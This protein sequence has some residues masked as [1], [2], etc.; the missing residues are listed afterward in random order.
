MMPNGKT[1]L[2]Y[3]DFDG[4]N[5]AQWSRRT[6]MLVGPRGRLF[7]EN[8]TLDDEQK[9]DHLLKSLAFNAVGLAL[10]QNLFYL[11]EEV[12]LDDAYGAWQAV[13]NHFVSDTALGKFS[14]YCAPAIPESHWCGPAH[15]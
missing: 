9:G 10:P 5:Y 15:R 1:N 14:A 6:Q 3:I 7:F 12:E 4:T 8:Q 2:Q 11:I 13:K